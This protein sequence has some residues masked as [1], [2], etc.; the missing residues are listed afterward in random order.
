MTLQRYM[1]ILAEFPPAFWTLAVVMFIDAVGGGLLFPF[2][3]LYITRR[4]EVGMT[5]VGLLFTISAG[6]G[7]VGSLL[8]GGITDRLGR[9][10]MILLSLLASAGSALV[11]GL[12]GDI[13]SFFAFALL[14]G[15]LTDIGRPAYAAMIADLLPEEKRAQGFGFLRVVVNFSMVLGPAIGGLLVS[16]SFLLLFISDAVISAVSAIVVVFAIPETRPASRPAQEHAARPSWGSTYRGYILILRD[17]LFVYF[18][19]ASTLMVLAYTNLN[20]TLGVFLR[21]VRGIPES[22]YAGLLSL[23]AALVVLFQF[24]ISRRLQGRAAMPILAWGSLLIAAGFGLFGLWTGYPLFILSM[25][26]ITLGEML[27]VP[28]SQAHAAAFAPADMRGRYMA[29]FG[30]VW[31]VPF[32]IGPLSAGF[33]MD[34]ADPR[35]L[36]AATALAGTLAAAAFAVLHRAGTR[37]ISPV[38]E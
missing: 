7:L 22:G 32:I 28:T 16:R 30:F 10:G 35:W 14:T 21:D 36:W 19:L 34:R 15:F 24:P 11:M 18:I 8:G 5:T 38:A 1:N 2:Y 12:V 33:L 13:T 23:N 29:A 25:I 9:K 20:T 6:A 4:F 26:V 27:V 17:R 37:R 31:S 3:A